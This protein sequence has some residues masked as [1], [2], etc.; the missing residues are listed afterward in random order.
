MKDC[1]A[2]NQVSVGT[3]LTV[4]NGWGTCA[5][6]PL[7][8]RGLDRRRERGRQSERESE[9]MRPEQP[10]VPTALVHEAQSGQV[11]FTELCGGSEAGSYLRLT[12]SCVTQLKAQGP[13]GT[14]NESTFV[15]EFLL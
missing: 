4:L 8:G 12:D 15:L 14:Y 9:E 2:I 11:D 5:A 6:C 7:A 1:M 10:S 13:L 3:S